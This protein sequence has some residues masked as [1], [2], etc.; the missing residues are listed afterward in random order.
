MTPLNYEQVK[1]IVSRV[2]YRPGWTFTMHG[3]LPVPSS[4]HMTIDGPIVDARDHSQTTRVG[5]RV[6]V[7]MNFR[8]E[9]EVMDW[10]AYCVQRVE[11]HE[12]REF[13]MLDGKTWD[14]PHA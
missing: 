7:P 1:A 12:S 14:D 11:I 10:I 8:S 4:P 3:A 9:T 13:L 6:A 2:T 5:W